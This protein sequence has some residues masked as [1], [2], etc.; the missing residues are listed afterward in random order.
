MQKQLKDFTEVET[1]I[2]CSCGCNKQIV[3]QKIH[4]NNLKRKFIHGHNKPILGTKRSIETIEKM[5][6]AKLGVKLS[7]STKEKM[8]KSAQGERNVMWKGDD[9]S[10]YAI[11]IWLKTNFGKANRCENLDGNVLTFSCTQKSKNYQWAKKK[12]SEYT[13][14]K[15]DYYNLCV[16]CHRKY[17]LNN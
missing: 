16:S 11:H 4:K 10:Y 8:R 3:F 15:K 7:E 2:F 12:A 9:A 14:F 13:R 5:R 6:K 17:D 1:E